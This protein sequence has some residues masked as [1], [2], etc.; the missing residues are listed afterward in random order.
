VL[1]AAHTSA[2]KTAIAEYAIALAL[3]EKQRVIYTSP[4]KAL[5]NQKYRE[6]SEEFKDVGLMTGDV[7]INEHASCLVMTTEILRSMLYRGSEVVREMAW[8]IFD[9][10]HYMRD[11]E[12]GVVWE[13]TIILLPEP[14]R[15][16]F[17]SATIPNAR[18][19]AEWI[20]KIKN[21][22]C[23]VVYT[24]MRPV[25]L[26]HYMYPSG[27]EGLYLVVDE[28][29][30][31]RE[32]NFQK[33]IAA[34]SEA[35]DSRPARKVAPGANSEVVKIVQLVIEQNFQPAIIFSFSKRECEA[36]AMTLNKFDF[37]TS[38]EKALVEQ[39]F[40]N[41]IETLS[42]EDKQLP[43]VQNAL[44]MLKKGVGIH[45]GGLL[46]IIK[47]VTEI[48]FQEGLLKILFSTETFSMGL[49]MPAKTVVFTCV[50]KFDGEEFRWLGGGEYIQMSGRAGR[51]GLDD[52]GICILMV[53]Q[54]MEPEVA[55]SMLKGNMDPL[56]SAFHLG[57]NMLLNLTRLEDANT[58]FMIKRSFHQFQNDK[59]YPEI[60]R[61]KKALVAELQGIT[62]Q[63]EDE[64][65]ELEQLQHA[66]KML[67]S[68]TRVF[69]HKPE[70]LL[71]FMSPGRLVHIVELGGVDWGWGVVVSFTKKRVDSRSLS[72]QSEL[73]VIVDVIIFAKFDK[74]P[75]PINDLWAEDGEAMLIPMYLDTVFEVSSV[76]LFLPSDLRSRESL[77]TVVVSMR[78]TFRR[79]NNKLPMIDPIL[80]MKITEP[81]FV[82]AFSQLKDI[83]TREQSLPVL[84]RP[85]FVQEL[86]KFKTKQRLQEGVSLLKGQLR[87]SKKT[88]VLHD[89]LKSMNRV[90]RRLSFVKDN[91]VE[92]K[93]RVACEITTS[94]EL[95]A[96][97]LML[98]GVFKDLPVDVM[99][100]LLSCLVHEENSASSKPPGTEEL[101]SAY[102][103]L[104]TTA[105]RFAEVFVQS[106][107]NVDSETYVNSYKP[108]LMEAV[109][110]WSRGAKFAEICEMTDVYEGSII[111][112]IRR[113][114]EV[115]RQLR[116]A[117]LAIG[118][119]ELAEK[120]KEG[121]G[122]IERGIIF[123]ASLYL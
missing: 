86:D 111:R 1:V 122:M 2:G 7:T 115:I 81:E 75:L 39:V 95:L 117:S 40:H 118:S 121:L 73:K 106:K 54:K 90:L 37:T 65:I 13:E 62:L 48:L 92:L 16:V 93:G 80:D 49:N 41:A 103:L 72:E 88:M 99:V 20:C 105:T 85:D 61:Q 24:E 57:Y 71:S 18:E 25:P 70:T 27:G 116:D 46:P 58:E 113:L 119:T 53:D 6:L 107:L 42:D 56:N 36:Y 67:H 8:V 3:R 108:S 109:Y 50:R 4:I 89:E 74:K 17:L 63:Y 19:F 91:M 76:R 97:E 60:L 64:L 98:S 96:T 11:K 26:Q 84:G 101:A 35:Q 78:E 32:R 52:K 82:E 77:K 94:D 66:K 30:H 112:C 28:K 47:E 79:L 100:A 123:A 59:A 114:H 104:R 21:Q 45:H 29:T 102:Q 34:L 10:I 44:P 14:V 15:L 51:R 68:V 23:H 5:S 83:N 55:K 33:A 87:A 31:F 9:E 120:F 12:R 22:P 43:M 110:A 69:T 38:E